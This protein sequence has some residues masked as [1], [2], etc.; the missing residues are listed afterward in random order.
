MLLIEIDKTRYRK[1]FNIVMGAVIAFLVV[2]SLAIAQLLIALYPAAEGS[3][4]HWNLLG[5]IVSVIITV[6]FI[7]I[8]KQHPFLIEVLYVWKLKQALN[9]VTRKMRKLL[10]AAKMGDK[11][12][13]LALQF[14]YSGSRQLWT[15]DD[16][17]ITLANL[18]KS[19]AELDA[20]LEK[21]DL[22]VD[23]K[24]YHS[25]LLKLF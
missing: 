5:V 4:F 16:N 15:L 1:H 10:I 2:A 11:N 18:E 17:T 12:A 19:Q 21:Y 20:L 14:S 25:D 6:I 13:M 9:L 23:I 7:N 3:H 22:I 8:N 24:E